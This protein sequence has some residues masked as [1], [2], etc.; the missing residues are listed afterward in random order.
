MARVGNVQLT[1]IIT[2]NS[3]QTVEGDRLFEDHATWIEKTHHREGDKAMLIY[4]VS[5]AFELSNPLDPTSEKTG[6]VHFILSEVYQSPAG[7]EDHFKQA[8]DSWAEFG[9]FMKWVGECNST[10]IPNAEIF[11]SLW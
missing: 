5:K 4:D 10:V 6:N 2:A 9:N 7:I 8:E 11:K 3:V 1:I